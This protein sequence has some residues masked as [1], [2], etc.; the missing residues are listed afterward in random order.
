MRK[1]CFFLMIAVLVPLMQGCPKEPQTITETHEVNRWVY[2]Q[3]KQYYLWTDSLPPIEESGLASPTQ[4][5]FDVNLRYRKNKNIQLKDDYR[6]D[7]FSSIEFKGTDEQTTRARAATEKEYDF[8]FLLSRITSGGSLKHLQV[9]Y[10]IPGTPAAKAGLQRG[11]AFDKINGTAVSNSNYQSLLANPTITLNVLN[12]ETE[13]AITMQKD[14]F[15]NCPILVDTIY[16]DPAK[17]A[18][19]AYNHFTDGD[20]TAGYAKKLKE[21]FKRYKDAEVETLIL[22]L[23]YNGGGEIENARLLATLIAPRES[24]RDPQAGSKGGLFMLAQRN[25]SKEKFD[26]FRFFTN[27]DNCNADIKNLYIITSSNTASASEL[28]IHTLRPI[29]RD[30]GR[31]MY[32]VGETTHGKNLGTITYTNSQ[33]EWEISPVSMRV[34]NIDRES[35][36]ERGLKPDTGRQDSEYMRKPA[37]DYYSL[38][39]LGDFEKENLLNIVMRRFHDVPPA[40]R[41]AT[42]RSSADPLPIPCVPDRGLSEGRVEVR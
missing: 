42:T 6:G 4:E 14:F 10:V 17:T 41:S 30:T 1:F 36:Y 8:G 21:A 35:G 23:R 40:T 11:D 32:V 38:P 16:D 29:F 7:R 13:G 15:Y 3:M 25:A 19:M 5:Y 27:V 37:E 9:L 39:P 31:T 2:R 22:D 28:I 24:L 26:E 20:D 34:Y 18:Y 33:Y 12:R